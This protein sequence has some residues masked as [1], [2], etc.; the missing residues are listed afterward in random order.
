MLTTA[1]SKSWEYNIIYLTKCYN[2]SFCK[3][4]CFLQTKKR[5]A[6]KGSSA[7]NKSKKSKNKDTDVDNVPLAS[8]LAAAK[9]SESSSDSDEEM[10]VLPTTALPAVPTTGH[11]PHALRKAIKKGEPINMARLLPNSKNFNSK[12]YQPTF[13]IDPESMC[14]RQEEPKEQLKFY[15]WSRAFTIFMS[16]RLSYFP[17]EAQSLLKHLQNVQELH[18]IGKDAIAYDISFRQSKH[19]H[20]SI[21]WGQW[22]SELVDKLPSVK[23]KVAPRPKTRIHKRRI[24]HNF[25]ND[26]CTY[27]NCIFPHVCMKCGGK[28]PAKTC[29]SI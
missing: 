4:L 9:T 24:C 2:P 26:K 11:V 25:N 16:I 12:A 10:A 1:L 20:P 29:K 8:L 15:D 13:A 28:H 22:L 23:P 14:F 7:K 5:S 3:F 6:P 18:A 19:Q 17:A 21:P 27:T